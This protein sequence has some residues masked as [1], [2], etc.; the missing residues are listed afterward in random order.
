MRQ[1]IVTGGSHGLG[2]AMAEGFLAKGFGVIVLDVNPC[3]LEGIDY[4]PMDLS[5]PEDIDCAFAQI[6]RRYGTAHVLVNN[7]AVTKYEKPISEV[8]VSDY[9]TILNTNLR[10]AYL[11]AKAFIALNQGQDY[12]RIINLASTRFHQN[13]GDWEL[14]GMSKGGIVSLT[15]S[16][17]VSLMGTPITV[18]AISP[19]YIH[20]GDEVL[21]PRDHQIHP[22]NRVGIPRDI[23]NVCL[24]LAD[25]ENDFINGANIVVD[26]GMTKRM[27][28]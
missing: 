6:E 12:G 26:G 7:G 24:F 25:E 4:I 23:A 18:N 10:G 5:K 16:L 28:Y 17:C 15:N 22:S 14:Y 13:E 27:I 1:A 2:L 19:G 8:S 9:D 11:C 3:P 21:E 20:T